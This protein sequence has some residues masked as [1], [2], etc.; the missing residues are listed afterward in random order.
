MN[1]RGDNRDMASF[2]RTKWI[3]AMRKAIFFADIKNQEYSQGSDLE[4]TGIAEQRERT[5]ESITWSVQSSLSTASSRIR[6]RKASWS[7]QLVQERAVNGLELVQRSSDPVGRKP[8]RSVEFSA[9]IEP[10][11][12]KEVTLIVRTFRKTEQRRSTSPNDK[13]RRNATWSGP[14]E[15]ARTFGRRRASPRGSLSR[16]GRSTFWG[17][18]NR[19]Y[20]V[21]NKPRRN[22]G[23]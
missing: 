5:G 21:T 9:K 19:P 3:P 22:D 13:R 2:W 20:R 23:L 8:K 7:S 15:E 16:C 4:V 11:V 1:S 14:T 12:V 6:A 17:K 18:A 10:F